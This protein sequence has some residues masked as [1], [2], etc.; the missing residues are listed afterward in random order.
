MVKPKDPSMIMIVHNIR[1]NYFTV[2]LLI[3]D[4][5][6]GKLKFVLF[7]QY[8]NDISLLNGITTF[9]LMIF[10][11]TITSNILEVFIYKFNSCIRN[12][13]NLSYCCR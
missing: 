1:I 9:K 4:F 2:T 12:I 7:C 10:R 5:S 13:L 11:R 3:F 8:L 6:I